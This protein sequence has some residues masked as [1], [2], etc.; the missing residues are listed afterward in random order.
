MSAAG[1]PQDAEKS[2]DLRATIAKARA[3]DADALAEVKTWFGNARKQGDAGEPRVFE[4]AE[5]RIVADPQAPRQRRE[6]YRQPLRF[7]P[8]D[9]SRDRLP[10]VEQSIREVR[11]CPPLVQVFQAAALAHLGQLQKALVMDDTLQRAERARIRRELAL[12]VRRGRALW[13]NWV[14]VTPER[15]RRKFD[16]LV[17]RWLDAAPDAAEEPWFVPGAKERCQLGAAEA[18]FAALTLKARAFLGVERWNCTLDE[19]EVV[20]AGLVASVEEAN[21]WAQLVEAKFRFVRE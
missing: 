13:E 20:C 21:H 2:Q 10:N 1:Q 7:V 3:G 19:H 15:Q 11:A 14:H 5:D 9:P 17:Q 8:L 6:V 16:R 4:V 18:F 12:I